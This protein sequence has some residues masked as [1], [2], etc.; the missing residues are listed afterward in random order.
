MMDIYDM[1]NLIDIC[2]KT[3]NKLLTLIWKNYMYMDSKR[4]LGYVISHLE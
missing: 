2:C 3:I 4:E 1:C